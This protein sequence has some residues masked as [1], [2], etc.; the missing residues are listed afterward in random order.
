GAEFYNLNFGPSVLADVDF[1][2]APTL[3]TNVAVINFPRT[4]GSFWPG[5]QSDRFAARFTGTVFAPSDGRYTFFSA[6]DDGAL[7][8]IDGQLVVNDGENH[9][10]GEAS[11]TILLSAGA[12]PF[13]TRFFENGGDAVLVVSWTG[14]GFAKQIIP[15]AAFSPWQVLRW[16][17]AGS[18]VLVRTND[19]A[20]LSATLELSLRLAGTSQVQVVAFDA[21]TLSSTQLVTIVALPDMDHD[22][23][24]DRDD[25]DIDGDGLSN[26]QEAQLGT[27]PRKPDTD[28][29]R[30]AKTDSR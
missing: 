11:G 8:Y 14:P 5:G 21:D 28:G 10:T 4:S 6:S 23:I 16:R 2:A 12:H 13:E 20:T 17:E 26:V 27:D 19:L 30:M 22:G 7:V 24:P 25:P 9:G 18:A 29:S 1:T 15:A 3:T